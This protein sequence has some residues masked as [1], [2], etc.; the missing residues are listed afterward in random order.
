[1]SRYRRRNFDED[2]DNTS[3]A[4]RA[5]QTYPQ[6]RSEG[7]SPGRRAVRGGGTRRSGGEEATGRPTRGGR[8]KGRLGGRIGEQD[9]GGSVHSHAHG[10]SSFGGSVHGDGAQ[11]ARPLAATWSPASPSVANSRRQV[12]TADRCFCAPHHP[13]IAHTAV[14]TAIAHTAVRTSTQHQCT[15]T[16]HVGPDTT[17]LSAQPSLHFC[18]A[19]APGTRSQPSPP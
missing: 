13:A 19:N 9:D 14:Y 6:S 3:V 17:T 1:M 11:R 2:D 8:S 15:A 5:A 10:G 4:S 16:C 12:T 7:R 18:G